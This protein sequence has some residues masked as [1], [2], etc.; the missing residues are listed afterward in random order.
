VRRIGNFDVVA[1][2]VADA[3]AQ[4]TCAV[5]DGSPA[6]FGFCNA[7]TAN[8]GRSKPAFVNAASQGVL[9]NDGVGLNIASRMLYGSP[10][11]A[12]LNGTDLTPAVLAAL[13]AGTGVFVIG[14]PPG[15]ANDAAGALAARFPNIRI[16]G[17]QHGFFDPGEEHAIAQRIRASGA[18]LVLAGMGQPRQEQW[19]AANLA[20]VGAVILC[21]GAYL[22]FAAGRF[23]RAPSWM[24][25]AG[26][27]WAF[28][29]AQ[30]PR[31]M[32][33]RY[34]VGNGAFLAAV[35][36][37]KARQVTARLRRTPTHR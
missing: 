35:S 22:D 13:P 37:Q 17:M 29:L 16:A 6:M 30:E 25:A 14:S 31:R 23:A 3:V 5:L 15:V 7:H 34:L 21:I 8:L 33:G 27:E 4:V 26:M 11:P 1:T 10:F 28:R 32:M 9:F 19:A 18:R 36:R 20:H 24:Q 12:N 2:T